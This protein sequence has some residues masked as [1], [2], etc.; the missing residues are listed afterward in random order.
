MTL[1][2]SR[3]VDGN[4]ATLIKILRRQPQDIAQHATFRDCVAN[5]YAP[6]P[7][8]LANLTITHSGGRHHLFRI[9][10]VA[11]GSCVDR[12][13]EHWIAHAVTD[14]LDTWALRNAAGDK[15]IGAFS[16]TNASSSASS[17]RS[18]H[19]SA[20]WHPRRGVIEKCWQK[21]VWL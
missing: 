3:V 21:I 6:H 16:K 12:C 5:G 8:T 20:S 15:G 1:P 19:R 4:S 11:G 9:L 7:Y 17:P 18:G 10:R 2:Q 14:D 13:H